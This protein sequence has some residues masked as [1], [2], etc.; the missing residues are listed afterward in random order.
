MTQLIDGVRYVKSPESRLPVAAHGGNWKGVKY[1]SYR[2][3]DELTLAR[4][5]SSQATNEFHPDPPRRID[6]EID[7]YLS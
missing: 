7:P 2:E 5:E 4:L 1:L 3:E 6:G